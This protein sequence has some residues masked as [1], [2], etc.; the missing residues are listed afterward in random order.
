MWRWLGLLMQH[1]MASSCLAVHGWVVPIYKKVKVVS[2]WSWAFLIVKFSI[3]NIPLHSSFGIG[4]C[5]CLLFLFNIWWQKNS[6][7]ALFCNRIRQGDSDRPRKEDILG[8]QK[9]QAYFVEAAL[10][11]C[12]RFKRLWS[13]HTA[14][15]EVHG[16]CCIFVH[17]WSGWVPLAI[18]TSWSCVPYFIEYGGSSEGSGLWYMFI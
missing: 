9:K 8:N 1:T 12:S 18:S 3:R 6:L 15:S 13:P 2:F 5:L 17:F 14:E 10:L 11:T 16:R 4:Y 7:K